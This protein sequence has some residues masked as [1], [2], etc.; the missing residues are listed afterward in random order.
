MKGVKLET[1]MASKAKI[2]GSAGQAQ[3]ET[4]VEKK[5]VTELEQ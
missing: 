1:K 3:P 4:P 5:G 2:V